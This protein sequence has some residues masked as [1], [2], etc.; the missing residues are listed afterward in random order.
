VA[1]LRAFEHAEALSTI[2]VAM[3]VP[4]VF[5]LAGGVVSDRFDGAGS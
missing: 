3:T 1:G 2:G 4:L 5:L